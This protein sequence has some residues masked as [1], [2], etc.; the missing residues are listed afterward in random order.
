MERKPALNGKNVSSESGF[1]LWGAIVLLALIAFIVLAVMKLMT[2][3]AAV[4]AFAA[5]LILATLIAMLPDI[6]RY[7]KIS[8]M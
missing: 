7:S 6:M 8:S 3:W 4:L 1:G 5:V 2:V